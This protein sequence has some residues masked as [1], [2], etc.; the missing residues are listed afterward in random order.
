MNTIIVC[1]VW[2]PMVESGH[3]R[4]CKWWV[5]TDDCWGPSDHRCRHAKICES[6][7]SREGETDALLYEYDEGGGFFPGP[8]F[9]CVH[10][11]AKR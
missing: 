9:G 7:K 11:E 8:D 6:G 4:D 5:V 10:W 2:W 3:C 1:G